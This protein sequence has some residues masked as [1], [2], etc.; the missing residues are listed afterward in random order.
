MSNLRFF[1]SAFITILLIFLLNKSWEIG[2]N[3]IPP[4]GK[5]LD[6]FHGFWQNIE[7]RDF[8]GPTALTIPGLKDKV[9][10]VY[11]SLLIPHIFASNDEDLYLAQGYLTAI[12][13]L[14]QMEFQTHAAAGR[15][16]E[17][18]G[19]GPNDRILEYDRGQRRLGLTFGAQNFLAAMERNAT[20]KMIIENYT[21][22]INQYIATLSYKS[23]PLEYKLL[24]YQ[25]ENWTALKCG[26][27]LKNMAQTLNSGDK[28]IEMTNA[29]TLFGKE[30]VDLLYPDREPP[31]DPIVDNAGKWNFVPIKLDTVP[32]ALPEELIAIQKLPGADPTTGSN[33][34]AVSGSKTATGS[35]ILCGDPHLNLSLPSIWYAIQL[36]A[37]GV[38]VMGVS[39]PGAPGVTIGFNDSIAWSVTNAQRDLIDW[40]KIT[41]QDSKKEKYKLDGQWVDTKKV[42]EEFNV[43]GKPVFYDTVIYTHWGPVTYD[44]SYHAEDELKNY[45]FRWISHDETEELLGLHKLNRATNHA[46]YM[47][48]LNHFGA[49][50]QNFVFAS[51]SGDIAMR[52]QG[53]YPVRR[54]DEGKFVLDGSNSA[55]GWQAYIPNEQNV[56]YKNPERGFVSS[57]NQYPADSTYP[58]YVTATNFEAYRNRRINQVLRESSSITIENMAKLQGDN[59]NLK[60]AESLPLFLSLLDTTT[61]TADEKNAYAILKSWNYFN[62]VDSEGASYYEAW[63]DQLM[64]LAWDEMVN[65]KVALSRPTTYNTIKLIKERPDLS[66]F[67]IQGTP[68]KETAEEVVQKSFS[69]GVKDIQAWKEN[70]KE[71]T[72]VGWADFKD[73]YVGHLLRLDPLSIHIKHGGNHDIVNAHSRTH[74]PSWRMIV[75]LEKTGIKS[76]AVYPG[77]Q[78]GNPGSYYYNNMLDRWTA[79][80]HFRMMFIRTPEEAGNQALYSTQLNPTS[81]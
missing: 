35:P 48:A 44:E 31:V 8:T 23:L 43:R 1:I 53:K 54:K 77:G 9:T 28:D 69:E 21:E 61:F 56:M 59:Y 30:T 39:L 2:G 27:L 34:W 45:A 11:D 29:L 74:G 71:Q 64:P 50:A 13:R 62:E 42:V 15:I 58:Y 79:D 41:Y 17:I 68:E 55:N 63:W 60:A 6:P 4:L 38:N 14:W 5:F 52:I 12:H 18:L 10:V 46:G 20:A 49:P 80:K 75:S 36:N 3:R 32:M 72:T 47:D 25:P 7:P 78:S 26:L 24:D 70:H 51:V 16:S 66:F 19:S 40:F 22:G 33:N 67:D 57:A 81:K 65:G 73:S 37:P 76:W